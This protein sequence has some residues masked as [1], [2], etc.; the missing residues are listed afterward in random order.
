MLNFLKALWQAAAQFTSVL[1]CLRNSENFWRHLSS[2]IRKNATSSMEVNLSENLTE[3]EVLSIAYRIQC[4]SVVLQI[5]AF[6]TFLQK[7]LFHAEFAVKQTTESSKDRV[8]QADD[9]EKSNDAGLLGLKDVLSSFHEGVVL[10]NMIKSYASWEYDSDMYL[11]AKVG[12]LSFLL[13]SNSF[14][15]VEHTITV[16][17]LSWVVDSTHY[18]NF[19]TFVCTIVQNSSFVGLLTRTQI[20][21]VDCL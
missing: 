16:T 8:R 12:F 19:Q 5:L 2:C 9:T 15:L 17:L 21:N 1:D 20:F 3:E 13:L 6:E 11:R 4:Q 7:K 18:C 14:F 10:G